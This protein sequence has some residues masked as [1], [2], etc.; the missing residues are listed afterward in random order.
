MNL[1]RPERPKGGAWLVLPRALTAWTGSRPR[2]RTRSGSAGLRTSGSRVRTGTQA[3][4]LEPLFRTSLEA[5]PVSVLSPHAELVGSTPSRGTE[6]ANDAAASGT[7]NW[8]S[9]RPLA[10]GPSVSKINF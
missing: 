9:T 6:S 7:T 3:G 5:W 4:R 2:G 10:P 1:L 8:C